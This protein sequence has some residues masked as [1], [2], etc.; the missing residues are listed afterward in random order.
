MAAD[1]RV[2]CREASRLLSLACERALD[3]GELDALKTHLDKCLM[4][5]NFDKQLR[6]LRKAASAFRER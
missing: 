6:F 4:C 5:S 2:N 1:K 3:E